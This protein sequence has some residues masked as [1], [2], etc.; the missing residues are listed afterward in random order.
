MA[1]WLN[2]RRDRDDENKVPADVT[3]TESG[4]EDRDGGEVLLFRSR[5]NDTDPSR[6]RERDWTDLRSGAADRDRGRASRSAN[7]STMTRRLSR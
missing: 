4:T 3:G 7:S 5:D 1:G 6:D 2:K